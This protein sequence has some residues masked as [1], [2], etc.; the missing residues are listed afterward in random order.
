MLYKILQS[1]IPKWPVAVRQAQHGPWRKSLEES[2]ANLQ[3]SFKKGVMTLN[4]R[5]LRNHLRV[6]FLSQGKPDNHKRKSE[7]GSSA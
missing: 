3:I 2:V 4:L 5:S 6:P 7:Q 1:I